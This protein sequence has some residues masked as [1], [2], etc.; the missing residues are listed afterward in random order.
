MIEIKS[1][2]VSVCIP[3]YNGAEYLS[4]AIESIF[5]QSYAYENLEIIISDD[6]SKDKTI[7]IAKAYQAKSP[8]KFSIFEHEQYGIAGNWNFSIAK[9]QGEY[10][11]FIFQDDLMLPDCI[12][13]MVKLAET[14]DDLGLIFSP[15]EVFLAKGAEHDSGCIQVHQHGQDVHTF[16][17]DLKEVQWGTDLLCDPQ[18]FQSPLNKV[19]EP[20]TVL[21]R[22]SIFDEIGFFDE[23]LH[24]TLDMDMWFR[25]MCNYKIGFCNQR[26]VRFRV[27]PHQASRRNLGIKNALDNQMLR[28]KMLYSPEYRINNLEVESILKSGTQHLMRSELEQIFKSLAKLQNSVSQEVVN[29]KQSE[30]NSVKDRLAKAEKYIETKLGLR[31]QS[32]R[33]LKHNNAIEFNLIVKEAWNAYNNSNNVEMIYLLERSQILSSL[34]RTEVIATWIQRFS[35]LAKEEEKDFNAFTLINLEEWQ[36]LINNNLLLLNSHYCQ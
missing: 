33:D 22:K 14:D 32:H 25:I 19:G 9:S 28:A 8:I 20:S 4:E 11:K 15:R 21:I 30:I 1:P 10:I 31:E 7:E 23:E 6:N 16:W 34:S 27:H 2:L 17:S 18:F 36:T 12:A 13:E 3:T 35:D 24:Q 26:L 5:A 29:Q